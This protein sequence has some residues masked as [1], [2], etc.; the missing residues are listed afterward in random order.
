MRTRGWVFCSIF[1]VLAPSAW[2]Q[3]SLGP[4]FQVN[5]YTT[6]GQGRPAV[7]VDSAGNFVLVWA[8]DGQDGSSTG[9]FARKYSASAT[10]LGSSEFRVNAY[11]TGQQSVPSVASDP[12]GHLVVVWESFFQDGSEYGVFGR[13]FD[14]SG[15]PGPEFRVNSYVSSDQRSASV[16]TDAA[17]NFVVVWESTDQVAPFES[18]IFGQRYDAGGV[19]Q[20]GE[21][22]VNSYTTESSIRPSVGMDDSGNFVVSWTRNAISTAEVFARRFNAAGVPQGGEFQVNAFTIGYQD[23]PSVSVH[24]NG[25][26]VIAWE[27]VG[28]DGDGSG[29]FA[30]RYDASGVGQGPEF[31]VN[32][33]TTGNQFEPRASVDADGRFVVVWTGGDGGGAGVFG[34]AFNAAGL[35]EGAEFQVNAFTSGDQS[36]RSVASQPGGR[37]VVAWAGAGPAGNYQYD[38]FARRFAK[39][40]IFADGFEGGDFSRWSSASTDS[41]DLSPSV[42]AALNSTT[43]GMQGVVDDTA[44]LFVQDDTPIDENRYRARFY[45][46]TNGFDP[47]ETSGAHRTRT[48]IVFEEAPTRRL[49]AIVLKRQ[50]GAY[51]IEGRCRLDSGA[52]A[53]TGFF[54]ISDGPHAVEIDWKR[55]SSAGANDGT[56]E[57]WIDG[58]SKA[59]LTGLSNSVSSVDFVRLGALSVKPGA[60]GTLYWD[61]FESRRISF[62]GS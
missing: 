18:S 3:L 31:R 14:P 57:L 30:R 19:P 22:Q 58:V 15:I 11:T 1:S 25:A 16:A 32:Q 52:Q 17:G 41:G 61:E 50:A 51:S 27:S 35:P 10:P 56:F 38:T 29:V 24:K 42:L 45:L 5:T 23:S 34:R 28:Q 62:I 26:F 9:I 48:F 60:S 49:A 53:D 12:T 36:A 43:V 6:Y 37:F 21:F 4:E 33:Y 39:D 13:R 40:V 46:D 54:P 2:A 47:G 55:S 8:S 7:A 20:G 59:Q 44:S